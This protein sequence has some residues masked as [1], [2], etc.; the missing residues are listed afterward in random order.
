MYSI[1]AYSLCLIQTEL[2]IVR[3]KSDLT[4][5]KHVIL[6]VQVCG[7]MN[8]HISFIHRLLLL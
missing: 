5:A 3:K 2:A 6:T 1:E 7:D 8:K 4:R